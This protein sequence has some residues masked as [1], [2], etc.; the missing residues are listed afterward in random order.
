MPMSKDTNVV[1]THNTSA[2]VLYSNNNGEIMPMSKDTNVV[3]T[4][5][6]SAPV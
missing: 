5:N 4:H 6:T 2:P 3:R 1:R